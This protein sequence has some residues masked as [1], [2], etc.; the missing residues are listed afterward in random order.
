MFMSKI[1][2]DFNYPVLLFRVE[3][4]ANKGTQ[5]NST[6]L[7]EV[8]KMVSPLVKFVVTVLLL[9]NAMTT[10]P[11]R[12]KTQNHYWR[13]GPCQ[14]QKALIQLNSKRW[15]IC[16]SITITTTGCRGGCLS[17]ARPYSHGVGIATS[18]SCCSPLESIIREHRVPGCGGKTVLVRLPEA[19]RC[20]F[21]GYSEHLSKL[22]RIEEVINFEYKLS[23]SPVQLKE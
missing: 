1:T 4:L 10:K 9:F 8:S 21:A 17:S 14:V 15:G 22:L 16:K 6:S 18:C 23:M 11:K 2:P 12:K 20:D 19:K 13:V 3:Y 5:E 7:L